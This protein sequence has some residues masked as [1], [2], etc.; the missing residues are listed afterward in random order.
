MGDFM[1][2]HQ[3][4]DKEKFYF[5]LLKDSKIEDL[6]VKPEFFEEETENEPEELLDIFSKKKLKKD[7]I[8]IDLPPP[9]EKITPLEPIGIPPPPARIRNWIH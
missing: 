4:R 8:V 2:E 7:R 9:I 1:K 3:E 6:S 5:R